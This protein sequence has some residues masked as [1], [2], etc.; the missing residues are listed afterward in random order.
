MSGFSARKLKAGEVFYYNTHAELLNGLFG[1]NYV[2]WMRSSWS[3]SY[4]IKVWF[5]RIDGK[6]RDD[7]RNDYVNKGTTII[8]SC[9]GNKKKFDGTP[10]ELV[11]ITDYRLVF[12]II[13]GSPRKYIFKGLFRYNREDSEPKRL[14]FEKADDVFTIK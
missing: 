7:F 4:N 5:G 9:S 14:I 11:R 2:K 1:T 10:L 13:D 12:E 3:Y 6:T 8:Q